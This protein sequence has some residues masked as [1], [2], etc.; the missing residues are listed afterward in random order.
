MAFY[1]RGFTLT[2]PPSIVRW[3]N[4]VMMDDAEARAVTTGA[5]I[6]T[7]SAVNAFFPVTAFPVLQGIF[8]GPKNARETG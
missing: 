1:L 7:A 6:S 8:E 4:I 3:V 5:M 2:L